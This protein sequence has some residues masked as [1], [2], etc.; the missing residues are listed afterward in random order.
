MEK[1]NVSKLYLGN[2]FGGVET[3]PDGAIARARTLAL[4]FRL[5]TNTEPSTQISPSQVSLAAAY[6]EIEVVLREWDASFR[7]LAANYSTGDRSIGVSF[8]S[9][10]EFEVSH[11]SLIRSCLGA[12]GLIVDGS[13]GAAGLCLGLPRL[14]VPHPRRPGSHR[15]PHPIRLPRQAHP[16]RRHRSCLT[17][18]QPSIQDLVGSMGSLVQVVVLSC[19][20]GGS[21]RLGGAGALNG[22]VFFGFFG[23]AAAAILLL[24]IPVG[25]GMG[26][27]EEEEGVEARWPSP[28]PS[29]PTRRST[30]GRRCSSC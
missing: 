20:A 1:G 30:R 18:L 3:D 13:A 25:R 2:T 17:S 8:W 19:L 5:K 14:L 23:L 16:R 10:G 4:Y 26:G 6:H 9:L 7:S 11:L 22:A 27:V 29:S 24:G 15:P 21:L 28:G 12:V